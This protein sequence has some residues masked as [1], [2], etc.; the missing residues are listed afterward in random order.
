MNND[1]DIT[2]KLK[3]H[4]KI[5]AILETEFCIKTAASIIEGGI[6]NEVTKKSISLKDMDQPR[7]NNFAKIIASNIKQLITQTQISVAAKLA[8]LNLTPRHS[9]S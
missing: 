5:V 3:L 1:K 7:L 4:Q 8:V 9:P 6:D 2:Q